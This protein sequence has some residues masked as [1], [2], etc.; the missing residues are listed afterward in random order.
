MVELKASRGRGVDYKRTIDKL[1][2]QVDGLRA[3]L[4]SNSNADGLAATISDGA[5]ERIRL[6]LGLMRL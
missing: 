5:Y 4:D 2:S 6:A 3:A 1:T